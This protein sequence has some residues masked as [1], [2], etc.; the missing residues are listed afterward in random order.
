VVLA[1]CAPASADAKPDVKFQGIPLA[2]YVSASELIPD[3][4]GRVFS[5]L[6]IASKY[7]EAKQYEQAVAILDQALEQIKDSPDNSSKAFLLVE[8]ADR[9]A[10]ANQKQKAGTVL[11]QAF[12]LIKG[13]PNKTD[14]V[15]AGVKIARTYAKLDQK[16]KADRL[17]KQALPIS[18][19]IVD[20]YA[21]SRAYEAIASALISIDD[22]ET[23]NTA[24]LK[25]QE[26]AGMAL[27]ASTRSRSL[28][29][30]A[31]TYAELK[32]HKNAIKFLQDAFDEVGEEIPPAYKQDFMARA[33]ALVVE[34]YLT[35]NQ[36]DQAAQVIANIPDTSIEKAIGL[37][38]LASA[39]RKSNQ[40]ELA[41]STL[42]QS[43][44]KAKPLPDSLDKAALFT[45][46]SQGY[47]QLDKPEQAKELMEQSQQIAR[48]LT[49]PAEKIYAL[50]S[51]ASQYA[52]LGQ[53]DTAK[54]LLDQSLAVLEETDKTKKLGNRD[55]AASDIAGLYWQV[56]ETAKAQTLADSL[57]DSPEKQQLQTLFNCAKA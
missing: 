27:E 42:E 13:F 20:V 26:Y 7:S 6:E 24:L 55:R 43:L 1:Y 45:E 10:S 4:N 35:T 17:L 33:F 5:L 51:L 12:T 47:R 15:F 52:D 18:A 49:N 37:L 39:Y 16:D 11:N 46:I 3:N 56:G 40:P 22:L 36:Y 54:Q 9:Y 21:K 23:A 32:D 14:R 53:M 31:G 25:G 30:L 19:D 50:S 2:C 48:K 44:N 28:I 8:L 38:N 41:L 29:E 57:G 34:R